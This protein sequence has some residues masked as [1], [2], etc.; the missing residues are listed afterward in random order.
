MS[1]YKKP[2]DWTTRYCVVLRSFRDDGIPGD[3]VA[4]C[5]VND[6]LVNR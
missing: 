3:D 1:S 5:L 6:G 4:T 2:N